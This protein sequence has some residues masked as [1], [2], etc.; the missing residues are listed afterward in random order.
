MAVG[1]S[2]CRSIT[3]TEDMIVEEI[4]TFNI[5]VETSNPNDMIMGQNTAV[6]T[7]VDDDGRSELQCF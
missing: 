4:E 5:T 2:V 1:N 7:I 3:I 6:V